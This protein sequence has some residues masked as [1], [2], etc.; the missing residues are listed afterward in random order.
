M[1]SP[2]NQQLYVKAKVRFYTV[3]VLYNTVACL[4]QFLNRDLLKNVI[5]N[6][7]VVSTTIRVYMWDW[8]MIHFHTNKRK[9]ENQFL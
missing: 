5:S 3:L 7:K 4:D 9:V 8:V 6:M 2:H 1:L